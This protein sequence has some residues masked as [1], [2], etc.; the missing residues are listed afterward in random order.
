MDARINKEQHLEWAVQ[1]APGEQRDLHIKYTIEYPLN[2]TITYY[3]QVKA[4]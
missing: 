3:N 1:L 4:C 2:E